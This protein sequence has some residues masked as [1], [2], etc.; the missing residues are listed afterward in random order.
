MPLFH[1]LVLAELLLKQ[2][3]LL[4]LLA[5]CFQG[6]IGVELRADATLVEQLADLARVL[7]LRGEKRRD[8]DTWK[9][10]QV[11]HTPIVIGGVRGF[12]RLL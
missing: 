9:A 3:V 4:S 7:L 11:R 1:F 5:Y 10:S 8:R 2:L 6:D 12:H